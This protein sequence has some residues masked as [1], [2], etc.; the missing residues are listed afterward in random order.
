[1]RG[2]VYR[3]VASN[4]GHDAFDQIIDLF[5]K[6]DLHEEKDRLARS[7]G[8]SKDVNVLQKVL[9]FAMCDEVRSQDT[10]WVIG[11]V[12]NNVKGNNGQLNL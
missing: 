7:L 9:D 6:A 4:G 2:S 12:A 10:P 3:I 11:S 1:M 8:A 5:R